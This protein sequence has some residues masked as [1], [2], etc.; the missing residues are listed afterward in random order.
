MYLYQYNYCIV[1]TKKDRFIISHNHS[2]NQLVFYFVRALQYAWFLIPI[3][4][5]T[6]LGYSHHHGCAPLFK[7][8]VYVGY[9][10]P[11]IARDSQ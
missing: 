10:D 6:I 11:T 2:S 4:V 8:D 1:M 7:H 9:D 3:V 5:A